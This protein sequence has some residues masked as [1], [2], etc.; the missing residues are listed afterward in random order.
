MLYRDV[1]GV[2]LELSDCWLF[3]SMSWAF[4]LVIHSLSL[5]ACRSV[6]VFAC[7]RTA[8]KTVSVV[9]LAQRCPADRLFRLQ[10][11]CPRA[12]CALIKIFASCCSHPQP[13]SYSLP[14]S[15]AQQLQ[16]AKVS[17]YALQSRTYGS[18]AA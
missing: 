6:F 13:I 12:N 2:R 16:S 4:C 18:I 10:Q 17:G 14:L 5:C 8:L 11:I 1:S 7:V 9:N 15:Q 3:L